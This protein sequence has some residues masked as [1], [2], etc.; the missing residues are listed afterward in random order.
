MV[1]VLDQ[2]IILIVDDN[3]ALLSA[4]EEMLSVAGF[5]VFSAANGAE[6]LKRMD[7]VTPHLII[8]DISMPEMDGYAFFRAVRA[9]PDWISIPF[10]FL[11]AFGTQEN[12]LVGKDLGAE[13]YLVKPVQRKELLIAVRSRLARSNQLRIARLRDAYESSLTVLANAIEVRDKYT[14]G[15]V[16]RVMN[17]ALMLARELG[18]KG[19]Q[20]DDLRFGAILHDIGKIQISENTLRK[21]D[22]LS[23]DEWTEVKRHPAA[24]AEMLKGI[25]YLATAIPAI[26]HHHE[27]WDGRGYP[28]SLTA[29]DIPIMARIVAVADSFDAMTTTRAYQNKRSLEQAANDILHKAGTKY[30][31]VVV[32]AFRR[33]WD[34]GKVHKIAKQ[35][36]K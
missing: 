3:T 32:E 21:D 14:R 8:S 18:W 19:K 17:Y 29:E 34:A 15:H 26:L 31:P 1:I 4:F 24:G 27:R 5:V 23:D 10:I 30:D 6:A 16:E 11:T 33:V 36:F 22:A 28:D 9:R 20:L 13:D 12:I 25:P 2:E 35:S 7:F